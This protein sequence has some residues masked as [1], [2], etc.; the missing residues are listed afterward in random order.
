MSQI[1][2]RK[3]RA[4]IAW[5]CVGLTLIT[6]AW[7]IATPIQDAVYLLTQ[8]L[9]LALI[10]LDNRWLAQLLLPVNNVAGVLALGLMGLRIAYRK[11]FS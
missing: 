2:R 11:I 4:V 1:A 9:T 3:R 7:L 6:S 8:G 10:D 5:I